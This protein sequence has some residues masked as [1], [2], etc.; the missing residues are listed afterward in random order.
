VTRN[1]AIVRLEQKKDHR[2]LQ[3]VSAVCLDLDSSVD[4]L[5][6]SA[7]RGQ[8]LA[9]L[10]QFGEC[11]P[12]LGGSP[13]KNA[14][15]YNAANFRLSACRNSVGTPANLTYLCSAASC[16]CVCLSAAFTAARNESLPA[17]ACTSPD[18]VSRKETFFP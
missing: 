16:C 11:L 8:A 9:G 4:D 17:G 6:Q 7:V 1:V 18:S 5:L 13:P 3:V 12:I 2:E 14:L 15:T 10:E